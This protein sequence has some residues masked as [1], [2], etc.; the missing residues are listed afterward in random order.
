MDSQPLTSIVSYIGQQGL[1]AALTLAR[2]LH[3]AIVLDSQSYRNEATRH[4]QNV[5]TWD[6]EDPKATQT[7]QVADVE[8]RSVRKNEEGL[9]EATD[10][11]SRTWFGKKLTLA[12]GVVDVYPEIDGYAERWVNGS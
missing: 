3:T 12:T 8:V 4:M 2:Q 9:F 7:I 5:L 11:G 6:H 1:T 10:A